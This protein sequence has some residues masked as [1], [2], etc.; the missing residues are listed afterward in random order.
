MFK[1]IFVFKNIFYSDII[2]RIFCIEFYD[3]DRFFRYDIIGDV[4]FFFIDV[5]LVFNIDEWRVLISFLL[6]GGFIGVS[7][8]M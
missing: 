3:F 7:N 2:N 4:K 1:E 5:D 8:I 6:L